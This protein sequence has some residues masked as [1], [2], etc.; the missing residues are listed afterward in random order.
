MPS[1][2]R[3]F[4]MWS[5]FCLL[6]SSTDSKPSWSSPSQQ[7]SMPKS[8]LAS[9]RHTSRSLPPWVLLPLACVESSDGDD[10]FFNTPTPI[11]AP[12]PLRLATTLLRSARLARSERSLSSSS[13][14]HTSIASLAALAAA[15][16][17]RRDDR[18]V[19]WTGGTGGDR[20]AA[21]AVL[22][23]PAPAPLPLCCCCDEDDVVVRLCAGADAE[24]RCSSARVRSLMAAAALA[25]K[26]PMD[27]GS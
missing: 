25:A 3:I 6:V 15:L 24:K 8:S 23:L 26:V 21:G 10:T 4:L 16:L 5:I 11:P 18:C 20:P 27:S 1:C 2:R 22:A 12:A 9:P 17:L 19:C 13:T 14:T 7:S